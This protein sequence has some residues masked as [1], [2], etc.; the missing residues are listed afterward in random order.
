MSY[1]EPK[2]EPVPKYFVFSMLPILCSIAGMPG[3]FM[4]DEVKQTLPDIV[5]DRKSVV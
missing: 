2:K 5:R 3:A 4:T 1:N